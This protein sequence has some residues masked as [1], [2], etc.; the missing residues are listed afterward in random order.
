MRVMRLLGSK[1]ICRSRMVAL[2]LLCSTFG[3][4]REAWKIGVDRVQAASN[5]MRVIF[6]GQPIR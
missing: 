6:Q 5:D 4:R 1:V 3:C 2:I